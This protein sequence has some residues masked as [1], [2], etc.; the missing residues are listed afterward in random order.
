MGKPLTLDSVHRQQ[1][2]VHFDAPERL[3]DGREP[4][5]R[6]ERMVRDDLR[7]PPC[8]LDRM[9]PVDRRGPDSLGEEPHGVGAFLLRVRA[10]EDQVGLG[11]QVEALASRRLF[12]GIANGPM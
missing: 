4:A 9:A 10:R 1:R 5:F 2:K 12:K 11:P 7:V 6:A 8:A 3:R